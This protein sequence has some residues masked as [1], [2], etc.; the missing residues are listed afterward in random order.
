MLFRSA[1]CRLMRQ[2]RGQVEGHS[3]RELF[4]ERAAVKWLRWAEEVAASDQPVEFVEHS[5]TT[6]RWLEVKAHRTENGQL[7]GIVADATER[8]ETRRKL[9]DSMER[10]EMAAEMAD[11]A[12]W[13]WNMETRRLEVSDRWCRQ[14]GLAPA[15]AARMDLGSWYIDH[16]HPEDRDQAGRIWREL[17]A[18]QSATTTAFQ[19]RLVLGGRVLW[20]HSLVRRLPGRLLG[21]RWDMTRFREAELALRESES[22]FR[23][24][25]ENTVFATYILQD[26]VYVYVNDAWCGMARY[27]REQ[28]LG[29][30]PGDLFQDSTCRAIDRYG[31]D[32]RAERHA[33]RLVTR[34]DRKSVV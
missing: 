9:G 22:L 24:I 30:P 19:Y 3:F 26:G 31:Q 28:V 33:V 13:E 27:G 14:V 2:T 16:L 17:L 6:G 25:A 8:L 5:F 4:G 7:L 11:L 18:G 12:V 15:E 20:F 21:V 23:S 34:R 1:Y 29:R 32:I 10:L